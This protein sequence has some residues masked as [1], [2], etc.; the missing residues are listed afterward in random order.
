MGSRDR[1]PGKVQA[2]TK[3]AGRRL[4]LQR[5]PTRVF[6]G[7][8]VLGFTVG[9]KAVI[10]QSARPQ[11]LKKNHRYNCQFVLHHLAFASLP[12]CPK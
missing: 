10:M 4:Q 3:G 12:Q 6:S 5:L 11:D 8:R 1:S 2:R 9:R 7:F